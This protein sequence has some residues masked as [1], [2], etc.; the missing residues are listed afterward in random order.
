[1]KASWKR[2]EQWP[3]TLIPFFLQLGNALVYP[4][5][6]THPNM[7]CVSTCYEVHAALCTQPQKKE[8]P[9]FLR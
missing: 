2:H 5:L 7:L 4:K 8:N 9:D 6:R 3:E 1:M